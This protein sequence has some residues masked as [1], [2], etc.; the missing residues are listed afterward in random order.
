[1]QTTVF[2]H[3]DNFSIFDKK[4]TPEFVTQNVHSRPIDMDQQLDGHQFWP[5][6]CKSPNK[7]N[8]FISKSLKSFKYKITRK[9][10]K[11]KN[12]S[13]AKK[14]TISKIIY[15]RTFSTEKSFIEIRY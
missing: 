2:N 4:F 6:Q 13:V 7:I 11:G 3:N 5:K 10:R 9:N 1:M 12:T 15:R 8:K 14:F